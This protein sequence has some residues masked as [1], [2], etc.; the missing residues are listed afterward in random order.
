[1]ANTFKP[2]CPHCLTRGRVR[3]VR[4]ITNTF[5]ELYCV[6]PNCCAVWSGSVEAGHFINPPMR[7]PDGR[8]LVPGNYDFNESGVLVPKSTEVQTLR[9]RAAAPEPDPRQLALALPA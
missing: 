3:S 2:Q 5:T 6:C 8:T 1:M 7:R 9:N 4:R